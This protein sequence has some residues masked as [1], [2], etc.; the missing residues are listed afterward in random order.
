MKVLVASAWL[1]AS[2][3]GLGAST[4]AFV[5][6]IPGSRARNDAVTTLARGLSSYKVTSAVTRR[7]AR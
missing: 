7:Q 6:V 5:V 2:L 1:V 4:T 3:G